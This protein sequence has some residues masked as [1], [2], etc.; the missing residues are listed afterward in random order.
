MRPRGSP[1]SEGKFELV[2]A[3][4]GNPS[5]RPAF[6]A[7]EFLE[8]HGVSAPFTAISVIQALSLGLVF[9]LSFVLFLVSL[10]GP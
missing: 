2:L 8:Q 4:I 9:P 7:L 3:R 5:T 10:R 1:A 6:F